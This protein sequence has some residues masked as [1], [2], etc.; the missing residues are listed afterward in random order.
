MYKLSETNRHDIDLYWPISIK[1]TLEWFPFLAIMEHTANIM[2][3][4]KGLISSLLKVFAMFG[5]RLIS[6][7]ENWTS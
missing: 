3:T 6:A 7:E 5:L 4:D 2:K 1:D